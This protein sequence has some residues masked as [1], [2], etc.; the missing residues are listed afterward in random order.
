MI[1]L[2]ASPADL[3]DDGREWLA[4]DRKAE[5]FFYA[6]A[7]RDR[8]I[9]ARATGANAAYLYLSTR[10]RRKVRRVPCGTCG[11]C[12]KPWRGIGWYLAWP[13]AVLCGFWPLVPEPAHE[14]E[15]D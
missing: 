7:Q 3:T 11:A 8:E 10:H 6:T 5:C 14:D 15:H 12:E 1:T 4:R 9:A 13:F 2:S